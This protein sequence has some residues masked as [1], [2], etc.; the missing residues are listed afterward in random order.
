M[1]GSIMVLP[2]QIRFIALAIALGCSLARAADPE[3]QPL[4][5]QIDTIEQR[6]KPCTSCHGNEGRATREGYFPRIA[7]KPAGY[8]FNQLVNFR[9]GR[10]HFTMMSYMAQLQS[11]D[12][13]HELANYFGS[14]HVPYPPPHPPQ[15]SA[16]TLER[17]RQLVMDG[18]ITLRVPACS[19]CHG[20]RLLGVAPVVPGLLGVSQDYLTA[21]LGAWRM[22]VRAAATPDCMSELVHRMRTEDLNAATA[23]LA[24]Q[25]VP[26][27]AEPAASFAAPPP[28]QCGSILAATTDSAPAAAATTT[29][30]IARGRELVA[31][32][33]CKSCHSA[34]GSA[35]FAGGRAI[36]TPFGTFYSPNITP[37]AKTGLGHWSATDFWHA[38]H[39][40]YSKDGSLLYPTFPYTN[41]TR[42]SRTD[43]DAIY[44]YLQTLEPVARANKAH[45]L[46]FP[47]S[48]RILLAAWRWLY[49]RAGEYTPDP[50]HDEHWNR[51]AYLVEGLGHCSACHESRNS[52]GATS[53]K[54]GPSGGLVLDWYAPSLT[55]PREA[56][57]QHWTDTEI[58]TLLKT[59]QVATTRTKASTIGPMAEVV[60]DSLQYTAD[61]DLHAMATY[62]KSLPVAEPSAGASV[63]YRI[64]PEILAAGEDLYKKNCAD[65]HGKHGEGTEPAAPPLAGNRAVTM[66][67]PIDSIRMILFGG[68]PPGTAGNPRPFG[69]P[70]YSLSLSDEQIAEILNYV[71][72][73][74]GN[75]ARPI[76][77]EEVSA[78]RG[79]PLW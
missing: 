72:T 12:Y 77:G 36:P 43:S 25:A 35:A 21:Q 57:V 15:V 28:L 54:A 32:G 22:G 39:E 2:M 7:G 19:A 46:R 53:P 37:D 41:Y 68:Y 52:L 59:G 26:D 76:F 67:S 13:L 24:S 62:L 79:S 60:N 14:Q 55:N 58:V 61:S 31:L 4:P 29:A 9:D 11:D 45:E 44:A 48:Q 5:A 50:T 74:W 73:S 20:P 56:G 69:M 6:V 78:N 70:P 40:G 47:Y 38:L 18:D 63:K 3:P 75:S 8:L 51:G 27:N 64:P 16:A 34:R 17:G 30:T 65:C 66:A 1:P 23:W 71:R 49:F 42:I 33:G 10:R